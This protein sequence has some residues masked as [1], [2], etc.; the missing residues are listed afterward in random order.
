MS[1]PNGEMDWI[2]YDDEVARHVDA[3]I[4]TVDVALYGRTTYGMMA[5][6]W[7]TMLTDASASERERHHAEWVQNV[8][9]LVF[10]TTLEKADWNNTKVIKDNLADEI[11]KLK[12]Q[13]GENLMIF[14]SPR[15][16]HAF[17]ELGLIDEYRLTVSPILV[18]SG[19]PLFKNPK[20]MTKFRLI[21]AKPF[22]VGVVGLHYHRA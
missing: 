10:S 6:Y 1:G 11:T 9:K 8:T 5:G 18:G 4:D 16:T 2:V 21:E 12:R 7:P 13:P 22:T 17:E 3:I 15:L 14:G 19:T 20:P